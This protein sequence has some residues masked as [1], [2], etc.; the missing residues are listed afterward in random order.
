MQVWNLL[1]RGSL[2]T[3][4]QKKSPKIAIWAPSHNFV[5]LYLRNE[6]TYR[7][8]E[9]NVLSSNMSSTCPHNM[10]KFGLLA[11]EIGWQVW[12]TPPNFNGL[13]IL[14]ALLHS[15][16]VVIV[17]HTL[18]RWTEDATYVRQGSHHFGYWSTFLVMIIFT[19][20]VPHLHIFLLFPLCL[21][22]PVNDV[23]NVTKAWNLLFYKF[24]RVSDHDCI[25]DVHMYFGIV[26]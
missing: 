25:N 17:S 15:S 4:D 13:R 22:H 16:K 23:V 10:V 19:H 21:C 9:K 12:G 11:A 5:G 8:S 2:K 6:G 1:L 14:A 24:F 20:D 26:I 18:R 7:Q 3:Q